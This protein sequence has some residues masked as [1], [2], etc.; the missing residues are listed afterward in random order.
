[1]IASEEMSLVKVGQR[2]HAICP[3]TGQFWHGKAI[4]T[5]KN[6]SE[7]R[8]DWIGAEGSSWVPRSNVRKPK[9]IDFPISARNA[10]MQR[11]GMNLINHVTSLEKGD[12]FIN[13]ATKQSVTNV[14]EQLEVA[15]NDRFMSQVSF[16]ITNMRA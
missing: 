6:N 7:V 13:V 9:P 1:M 5:R 15:V 3:V 11:G 8:V 14:R 4:A 16:N 10:L 2:V 12:N